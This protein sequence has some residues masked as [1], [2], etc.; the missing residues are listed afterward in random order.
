V[1]EK[2][3][4]Q[5]FRSIR[6]W[7]DD[8]RVLDVFVIEILPLDLPMTTTIDQGRDSVDL[9]FFS[10]LRNRWISL[11]ECQCRFNC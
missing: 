9:A 1:I 10:I 11:P 5:G 3:S 4:W 2:R 6:L 7:I 8:L